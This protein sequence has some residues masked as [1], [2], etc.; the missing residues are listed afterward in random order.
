M[1]VFKPAW[2]TTS[3]FKLGYSEEQALKI[4][5]RYCVF[6]AQKSKAHIVPIAAIGIDEKKRVHIHA[7]IL[8]DKRVKYRQLHKLWKS[9]FS[10]QKLYRNGEGAI[11]YTLNHHS[12]IPISEPFCPGQNVCRGSRGC[13]HLRKK[14]HWNP[15]Q[16]QTEDAHARGS[17][18]FAAPSAVNDHSS[19][20]PLVEQEKEHTHRITA[21]SK[22]EKPTN[23]QPT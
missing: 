12:Y 21:P 16:K 1:E 13:F 17:H 19:D 7:V 18:K 14:N 3:T 23:E 10:E 4:W 20:F 15:I 6:V 8:T 22:Q 2:W 9:G 11:P 5:K